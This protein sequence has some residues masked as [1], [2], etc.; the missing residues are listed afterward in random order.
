MPRSGNNKIMGI[1][2]LYLEW[3][4]ADA[5]RGILTA[6]KNCLK[7]NLEYWSVSILLKTFFSHWRRYGYSY[8]K[9]FDIGRYFEVFTFNIISRVLG[10]IM[11]S[12]LIMLGLAAE[13][14]IF[15]LGLAVI[16]FWLVL[17]VL[18]ILGFFYG[19]KILL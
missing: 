17:P 6:W 9:G 1:V 12:V 5:P 16:L 11:R 10:A 7:F 15:L 3:Q 4:F 8:G 2:I 13:V 18:L 19:F 14:I